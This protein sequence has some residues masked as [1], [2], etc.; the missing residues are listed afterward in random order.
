[1]R[2]ANTWPAAPESAVGAQRIPGARHFTS[3]RP[4]LTGP[5]Y[6]GDLPFLTTFWPLS[7]AVCLSVA[8]FQSLSLRGGPGVARS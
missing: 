6:F 5:P 7:A 4:T 1:M 3:V 2:H 8:R